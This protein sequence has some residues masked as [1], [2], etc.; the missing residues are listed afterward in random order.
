MGG[1]K[2][3]LHMATFI[4]L[5]IGGVNWL[6]VGLFQWDIGSLFGG[7]DSIVSRIIYILIGVAAVYEMVMHKHNCRNCK[8]DSGGSSMPQSGG[9]AANV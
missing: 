9:G 7:M 8:S 3:G 2:K 6:L 5:V 1:H 4:L